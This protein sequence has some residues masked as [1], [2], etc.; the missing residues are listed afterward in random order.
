MSASGADLLGQLD[1][2]A[3][4]GRTEGTAAAAELRRLAVAVTSAARTLLLDELL[5]GAGAFGAVLDVVRA[6]HRLELLVAHHAVKDVGTR[7]EAENVVIERDRAGGLA[8][9]GS[10]LEFH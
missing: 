2:V 3:A 7:L 1:R 6:G 5:A 9:E 4:R 10:D 8:V